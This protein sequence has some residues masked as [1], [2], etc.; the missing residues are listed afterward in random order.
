MAWRG[1]ILLCCA[2]AIAAPAASQA[3]RAVNLY[4][5]V[6]ISR[7]TFD[8]IED[9]RT[10]ARGYWCAAADYVRKAGL[11]G[12][13]KRIFIETPR[14]ASKTQ[15]GRTGVVFTVAP[16]DDIRDTPPSYSVTVRNRGEN[17]SVGHAHNFCFELLEERFD[18]F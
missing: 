12:P 14:G 2:I 17:L 1:V 11:D 6:P 16:G 7:E 10:G 15:A 13:R 3:F 5:V 4:F 8:V 18:R 9:R